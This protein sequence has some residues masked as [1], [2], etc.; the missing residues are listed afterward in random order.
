MR[1]DLDLLERCLRFL[2]SG[3]LGR[4][5]GRDSFYWCLERFRGGFSW[6]GGVSQYMYDLEMILTY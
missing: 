3:R 4:L 2:L 1:H 5:I 6:T